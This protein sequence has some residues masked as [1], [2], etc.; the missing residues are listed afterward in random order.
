MLLEL[1]AEQ[2]AA[3]VALTGTYCLLSATKFHYY[4]SLVP[5]GTLMKYLNFF[6]STID[7]RRLPAWMLAMTAI[8]LAYC[9]RYTLLLVT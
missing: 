4:Y 3:D 6:V 7:L 5:A 8:V 2:H 9:S 1:R